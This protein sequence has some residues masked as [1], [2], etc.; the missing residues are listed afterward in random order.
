MPQEEKPTLIQLSVAHA[1]GFRP[2]ILLHRTP[3]Y[4][5]VTREKRGR[6][7]IVCLPSDRLDLVAPRPA[8]STLIRWWE[9]DL[10]SAKLRTLLP[11]LCGSL[12]HAYHL[13]SDRKGT[14]SVA[15]AR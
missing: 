2:L 15:K 11:E 9:D 14:F 10:F 13:D 5:R 6:V 8:G 1:F 3:H 12:E 4:V 7:R